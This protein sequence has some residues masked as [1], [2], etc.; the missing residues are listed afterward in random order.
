MH[1][2]RFALV[3]GAIMV[4]MGLLAFLPGLNT[5]PVEAGL[6]PLSLDTSYGLFLG[7]FPMNVLNK[8]ALLAFGAWGIIAS[9]NKTRSLPAS[10][11]WASWVFL[12]MGVL[13]ILG[14]IPQTNTLYGNWPLF[15]NEVW[16]HTVFSLLGGYFG[17]MLRRK[18]H[19]NNAWLRDERDSRAA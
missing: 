12:S 14:A 18:A 17:L 16:S 6:P 4:V 5:N 7:L 19:A 2:K 1:P 3:G 15:G 9:Q 13:A 8:V 11:N 10:T